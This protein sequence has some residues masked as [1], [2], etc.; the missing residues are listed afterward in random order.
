M[1]LRLSGRELADAGAEHACARGRRA[2]G[3]RVHAVSAHVRPADSA[4]T[5]CRPADA[6]GD[7]YDEYD[8]GA[9]G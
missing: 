9:G 2:D 1:L 8:Y 7:E 3:G 5:T 4:A 6:G